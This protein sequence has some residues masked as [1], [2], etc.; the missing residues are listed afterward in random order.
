M[1]HVKANKHLASLVSPSIVPISG[2]NLSLSGFVAGK[3]FYLATE[4]R[5]QPS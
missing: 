5:N 3:C 4:P 1:P 2:F